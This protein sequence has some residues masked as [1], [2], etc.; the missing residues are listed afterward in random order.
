MANGVH[1]DVLELRVD[2]AHQRVSKLE[3]T[4]FAH[5]KAQVEAEK[6][7][8]ARVG[9]IDALVKLIAFALVLLVPT[10]IVVVPWMVE[11]SIEKVLIEHGVIHYPKGESK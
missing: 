3:E 6:A 7:L 10:L 9:S 2:L 4:V 1:S 5:D 11:R 8:A